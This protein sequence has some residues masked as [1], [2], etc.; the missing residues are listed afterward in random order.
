MP[1]VIELRGRRRP[2]RARIPLVLA[3]LCATSGAVADCATFTIIGDR[4][5]FP[6]A[7]IEGDAE[8]G[9]RVAQDRQ[10]GDCV[11]CH[12]L[13]LPNDRFHGNLG[14]DLTTVGARLSAA[15][16]RL[17]VAANRQLNQESIMPDYCLS[18]DRHRV[19]PAH[20]DRPLLTA[21]EIEDLVVWLSTLGNPEAQP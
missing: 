9:A 3:L 5:E 13:P 6:L 19:A 16:I 11:I 4:I 18:G 10:R 20:R 15:Q 21:R 1:S 14:P 12:Q 17:R 2:G 7:G 8:A